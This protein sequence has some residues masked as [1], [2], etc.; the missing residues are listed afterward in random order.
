LFSP[1]IHSFSFPSPYLDSFSVSLGI[2]T[3]EEEIQALGNKSSSTPI[4][5]SLVLPPELQ[6]RLNSIIQ[7][8]VQRRVNSGFIEPKAE[9]L[10][11]MMMAN[12]FAALL[13]PWDVPCRICRQIHNILLSG[14]EVAY[15][16]QNGALVLECA[17]DQEFLRPVTDLIDRANVFNLGRRFFV[18]L[19]DLIGIKLGSDD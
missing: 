17:E 12:V 13:G 9:G 8:E 10:R 4:Q 5:S 19:A 2:I 11:Q 6:E 3:L 18:R 7:A 1:S 14:D 15:L 16:L